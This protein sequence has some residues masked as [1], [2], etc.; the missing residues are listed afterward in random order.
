MKSH[1][2]SYYKM[3]PFSTRTQV[4]HIFDLVNSNKTLLYIFSGMRQN[5]T[6]KDISK[7]KSPRRLVVGESYPMNG[8]IVTNYQLLAKN[9][10]DVK[11]KFA[12]SSSLSNIYADNVIEHL[13]LESAQIF[14][15][16]AYDALTAD[17]W[18]RLATPDCLAISKAY[19][20]NDLQKVSEFGKDLKQHNLKIDEP[21]D[22]LHVTF[23][24]FGHAKG[25][26]YDE[27]TLTG[28]LRWAGFRHIE[29]FSPSESSNPIFRNLEKR[30]G[31]S[32]YWSQ[33]CL[34]AK[35]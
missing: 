4:H 28:L 15:K 27:Q 19:I 20:E 24:A 9:F 12:E 1:F 30:T 21:I 34:E 29:R 25:R 11:K 17:G 26:I 35:K 31:V 14:L 22:L 18:I 23:C 2:F 32:D 13:D 8:W 33:M 3:L 7:A 5:K 6:I 10:I 16:N